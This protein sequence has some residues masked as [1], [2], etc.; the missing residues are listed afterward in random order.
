MKQIKKITGVLLILA[1]IFTMSATAFAANT[2]A[3]TITITN[4]KAGH[5][6]TA[7]QVFKGDISN[8]KLTNIE[9]GSGVNGADLLASLKGLSGSPYASCI[10][11]EEVADVL[12]G[13]GNDSA[14]LDEFAKIVGE[15]LS[16]T[17]NSSTEAAS[18][19]TINVTGDGY[20]LVKDSG[21]IADNDAA[22]KY[23]LK[24]VEDVEVAAKSEVPSIDK[25]IVDADDITGKGTAQDVG[26]SVSF[27]LTSA[28][29][30]MDGY[31]S[32]A[33]IVN[34]TLSAGLTFNNDVAVT[35]DG[36]EYTGFTVDQNGQ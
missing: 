23:I 21:T 35:I 34:D 16:G 29:P 4:D 24:V 11:A 3:H 25:I 6:Y 27:K 28:V 9:W 36:T 22:T 1:M 2:N 20:Y 19:Y 18:S 5:A 13:F 30:A 14:E 7:Y 12:M 15:H 17:C 32:Y 26:S 33:Y 31:S 8:G 10:S